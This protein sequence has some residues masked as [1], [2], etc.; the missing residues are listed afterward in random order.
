MS[1][2][3][4]FATFVLKQDY[5][6]F[7]VSYLSFA[8]VPPDIALESLMA[9]EFSPSLICTVSLIVAALSS[10]LGALLWQFS[11]H[12]LIGPTSMRQEATW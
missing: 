10:C 6:S 11:L 12:P 5:C 8:N 1:V 2:S 4:Q 7:I 3:C 9:T